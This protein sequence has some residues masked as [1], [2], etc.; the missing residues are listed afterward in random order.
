MQTFSAGFVAAFKTDCTLV[1]KKFWR[2]FWLYKNHDVIHLGDG[3]LAGL[4]VILKWYTKK[5]VTIT[6]HGLDVTYRKWFYQA[7]IKYCLPKLDGIMAVSPATKQAVQTIFPKCQVT[8]I[9]NGLNMADW[10][11]GDA[12]RNNHLLFV[13]RLVPRKGCAWFVQNVFPKLPDNIILDVIG[14][15]EEYEKLVNIDRVKLHGQVNDETLKK[16][17]RESAMLL[18]PNLVVPGN[19]EGFGIVAIEAGVCGLPV[20]A[21]K[22]EGMESI[23]IDGTTGFLVDSGDVAAWLEKIKAL[24]QKPLTSVVIQNEIVKRYNWDNV[25]Q[26]YLKIFYGLNTNK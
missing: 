8:V 13:G 23:I 7:Y 2:S 12:P 9:P 22:L 24:Q 21:A 15:G 10:P 16:F 18:M 14:D 11:R 20:L 3:V 25:K 17:Y 1:Y 6:V 26:Q 19:M 5:P 4:G